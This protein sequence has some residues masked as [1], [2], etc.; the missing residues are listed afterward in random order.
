MLKEERGKIGTVKENCSS[1]YSVISSF[2]ISTSSEETRSII[3]KQIIKFLIP[4]RDR[5]LRCS[6]VWG[7]IPSFAEITTITKS[8]PTAPATMVFT[9]FSCPGVSTIPIFCPSG[10]ANEVKPSSMVIPLFFS[11]S[12]R[13]ASYPV[14][15]LIKAVLP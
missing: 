9:N 8:I 15:A 11:S 7:I 12:S 14:K 3:V 1:R 2:L 10:R 4:R 6:L 5:I 13:S